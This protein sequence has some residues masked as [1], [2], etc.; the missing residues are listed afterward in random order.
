[1]VQRVID[2]DDAK[3]LTGFFVRLI[4]SG[5]CVLIAKLIRDLRLLSKCSTVKVDRLIGGLARPTTGQTL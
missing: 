1:M 3:D 4:R 2:F 5:I